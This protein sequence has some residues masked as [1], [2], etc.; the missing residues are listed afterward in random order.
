[1]ISGDIHW[2]DFPTTAGHAQAGRRPAVIVQAARVTTRLSTV[3]LVPLTS[4]VDAA[5]F[6]GTTVITPDSSN[7]LR[8]P[9]VAL[10]FQITTTDRR[11]VGE[12]MGTLAPAAMQ[13]ITR[14]FADVCVLAG[15]P[16]G[17]GA[18]T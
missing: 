3:I 7:G 13:A 17:E 2:V 10:A 8:R 4:R 16:P 6:P 5:R 18:V 15:V 9:S 1:M 11:N 14:A 12:R